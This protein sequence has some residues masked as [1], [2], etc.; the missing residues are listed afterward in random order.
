VSPLWESSFTAAKVILVIEA[1]SLAVSV[2][3]LVS[4]EELDVDETLQ[5]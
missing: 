5:I 4:I 2:T 3:L 1:S